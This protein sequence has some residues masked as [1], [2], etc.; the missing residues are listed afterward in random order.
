MKKYKVTL[1][2]KVESIDLLDV[3]VEAEGREDAIEKAKEKYIEN[4]NDSDMR[5]SDYYESRLDVSNHDLEV[6]EVE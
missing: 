1:E 5:A 2:F 4:P 3:E 6:E